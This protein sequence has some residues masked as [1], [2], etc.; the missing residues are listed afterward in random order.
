MTSTAGGG[1]R[2]AD[3]KSHNPFLEGAPPI[4]PDD[5]KTQKLTA[6]QLT[7]YQWAALAA[8]GWGASGGRTWYNCRKPGHFAASCTQTAQQPRGR[9]RGKLYANCPAARGKR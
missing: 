6:A 8:A 3:R 7:F 4:I 2:Q 9:G 1:A 5:D